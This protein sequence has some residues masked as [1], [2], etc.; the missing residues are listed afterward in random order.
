MYQYINLYKK[1]KGENTMR[2]RNRLAA[3]LAIL[4]MS[5]TM[6]ATTYADE[7]A[8]T[9][10][11]T[12]TGSITVK[13]TVE[14]ATYT[15]YKIFDATFNGSGAVSYTIPEGQEEY[16]GIRGYFTL[17]ANGGKTYVQKRSDV[18]DAALF[19]WLKGKGVA[20]ETKT[21][22]G[23]DLKFDILDFGYYYIKSSV[24]NGAATM[25][26]SATPD[27]VVQE[28]NGN[29]TWGG[30]SKITDKETYSVGD[31]INY[32]VT[33]E[34]ALNF[35]TTQDSYGTSTAHKIYQYVL[36]DTMPEAVT[37]KTDLNSFKVYINNDPVTVG[38]TANGKDAVVTF[39]NNNNF[40]VTIPWA[41]SHDQKTD[42][43]AEDF[44]YNDV[45][46]TIKVTY[47]GVLTKDATLGSTISVDHQK[48]INRAK[49]NPNETTTDTGREI[50]VYSG[51]ITIDKVE[52]GNTT[53]KLEGAKFKVINKPSKDDDGVQYLK[54]DASANANKGDFDWGDEAD[55]TVY[56]TDK[57]GTVEISGLAAG[58]YYLL[59]I[60]APQGYNVLTA[61][62]PVTLA[63]GV[64]GEKGDLLLVTSQVANNKGT[65]LPSTGGMGTVAFAVVGLIVMAGAAVTLIIKK[66]A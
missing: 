2:K 3:L 27:A 32:T 11:A 47:Q 56:T 41:A 55:A 49:I 54:Y 59:E 36:D 1:D 53:K 42:G 5:S 23:S 18:T 45:P 9:E 35:Y 26:S 37:L 46:A 8:A 20:G 38:K 57:N 30:G 14:N 16:A 31:T 44:Y 61:A 60:E 58:T 25:I 33:Y 7:S 40:K 66:R 6:A 22:T 21:G 24:E 48:N 52:A 65:L 39:Y 29:P 12:E 15:V 28:K 34:N 63:K 62:Q 51:K 64:D 17:S 10:A 50:E 13:N 4:I 19:N 43:T